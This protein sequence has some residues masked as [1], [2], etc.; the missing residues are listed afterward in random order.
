MLA[1]LIAETGHAVELTAPRVVVG[2]DADVDIPIQAALGLAPRHFEISHTAR[3]FRVQTLAPGLPLLV[4]GMPVEAA[5]L[6][7]G[8]Q[9][10]AGGLNLIF[11]V[12]GAPDSTKNASNGA[13]SFL[14]SGVSRSP[15][16][17]PAEPTPAAHS[18]VVMADDTQRSAE[19]LMHECL[20][21]T[22]RSSKSPK[23]ASD[24]NLAFVTAL[25]STVPACLACI[26][27]SRWNSAVSFPA[28]L[29]VG[30][31]VGY[32]V[33]QTGKGI[34]PRFGYLAAAA[35]ILAVMGVN[36]FS[37]APQMAES[38]AESADPIVHEYAGESRPESGVQPIANPVNQRPTLFDPT[39]LDVPDQHAPKL[40]AAPVATKNE[41]PVSPETPPFDLRHLLWLLFEPG[42]LFTYLCVGGIG[43]FI[44]IRN[45]TDSKNTG[46]RHL[47]S[48]PAKDT[49]HLSL[50]ERVVLQHQD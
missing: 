47:A 18:P 40:P 8:D 43:Y 13:Q 16:E 45:P 25:V 28:L 15:T 33:R 5:S 48:K 26:Y 35:S 1:Q 14:S 23:S 3:G 46:L 12:T 22:I 24:F 20:V 27:A 49:S 42:A 37:S 2:C 36:L 19:K 30:F 6:R 39:S 29:A 38:R 50:R 31:G 32:L 41:I 9:I 34:E 7:N 4:N 21:R 17:V 44:A 10:S 11:R